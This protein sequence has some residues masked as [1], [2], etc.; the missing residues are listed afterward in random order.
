MDLATFPAGDTLRY[1]GHDYTLTAVDPRTGIFQ[2][3]R[4]QG[5]P[6]GGTPKLKGFGNAADLR[7]A[8]EGWWYLPWRVAPRLSGVL[9]QLHAEGLALDAVQDIQRTAQT[10]IA[11]REHGR[12]DLALAAALAAHLTEAERAALPAIPGV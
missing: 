10:H 11:T 8:P 9:A 6:V 1:E 12:D 2:F 7:Q 5:V 4:P 3:D